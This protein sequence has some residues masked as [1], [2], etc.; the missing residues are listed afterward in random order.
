MGMPKEQL[1][2]RSLFEIYPREQAEGYWRDDQEVLASGHPKTNIVEPMQGLEGQ[3]WLQTGKVLCRDAQGNIIGV[4][5]FSL[6][7]TER[8]QAEEALRAT[9][10]ELTR[11]NNAMIGRELRMI[12]LKQE[13]NALCAQLAQPPRYVAEFADQAQ[14]EL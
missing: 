2:G 12:E 13:I 7:I 14:P 9:N 1:E 5:G 3:R 11:F 8:K 4:I 10:D 6:D